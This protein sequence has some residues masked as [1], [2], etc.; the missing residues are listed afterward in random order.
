M[1]A[2]MLAS[3]P[4]LQSSTRLAAQGQRH[5]KLTYL[6]ESLWLPVEPLLCEVQC[7]SKLAKMN[8]A[9]RLVGHSQSITRIT[10]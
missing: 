5:V 2:Y 8:H 7:L 3:I 10:G 1:N 4:S 6:Q 9:Q